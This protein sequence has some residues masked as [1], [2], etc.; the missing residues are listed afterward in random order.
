[1][2]EAIKSSRARCFSRGASA[3]S[4]SLLFE[5]IKSSIEG[6]RTFRQPI[7]LISFEAQPLI[8]EGRVLTYKF[9]YRVESIA[10]P[11]NIEHIGLKVLRNRK[12]V[13]WADLDV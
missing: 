7:F 6:A 11:D 5:A 8:F 3:G 9:A 1:M 13:V 4:K 10:Q 2:R 12:C